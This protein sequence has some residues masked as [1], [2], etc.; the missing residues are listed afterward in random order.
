MAFCEPRPRRSVAAALE[1]FVFAAVS[2][3]LSLQRK[4]SC[5]P[6]G[7][8]TFVVSTML[9]LGGVVQLVRTPACHAGGRGFESRR[10]RLAYLV[11]GSVW[12]GA[13]SLPGPPPR[14]SEIAISTVRQ[15]HDVAASRRRASSAGQS[16]LARPQA[17]RRPSGCP[18]R[19]DR[20]RN[21]LERSSTSIACLIIGGSAR[22]R[23][24]RARALGKSQVAS[25]R[26]RWERA[27]VNRS[28][29]SKPL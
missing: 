17:Q 10:S 1:E 23:P 25:S 2:R 13:T 29:N 9:R 4:S 26:R 27:G 11:G 14:K 28:R 12:P 6:T 15:L 5:S 24:P 18:T 22:A 20:G 21:P 3:L 7:E 19:V 16:R 8:R